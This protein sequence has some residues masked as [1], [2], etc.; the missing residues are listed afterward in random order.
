MDNISTV[1]NEITYGRKTFFVTP[2][3][4]LMPESYLEDY[5]AHGYEAYVIG[6]NHSC[7]LRK[8]IDLIISVFTDCILFFHIDFSA[9]GIEWRKYIKELQDTY[10][11]K[12][13]I[14]VLYNKRTK[15][16]DARQLEK[17]YLMDVGIQG[18]CIALEFQRARNFALIDK[19]MFANQ[20]C[21]RRKTVRALCDS[22]SELT[23]DIKKK[24]FKAKLEDISLDHFSCVFTEMPFPIP[25]YEKLND[26]LLLVNGLHFR[27]NAL[28]IMQ[29]NTSKGLLHIFV[30]TKADGTP[31]LDS[32]S[33]G[34]LGKKI[35][36]MITSQ[37]KALMQTIFM[38]AGVEE[39]QDE[40]AF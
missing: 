35:Y 14:G 17:Y 12:V 18:G 27:A 30:F 10:G 33:A 36:Q 3:I 20:S 26:V 15:E 4:S 6:E 9:D 13:I 16:E 19:V 40:L 37:T 31:G 5:L 29:R 25:L 34:R 21:G 7:S 8:K 32:D 11:D 22:L 39:R 24:R 2:D 28:L 23:F 1:Q 38:Q